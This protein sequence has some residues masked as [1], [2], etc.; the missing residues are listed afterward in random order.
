MTTY[1]TQIFIAQQTKF[2][3]KTDKYINYNFKQ[4]SKWKCP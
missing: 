2:T 4:V 3:G 1:T